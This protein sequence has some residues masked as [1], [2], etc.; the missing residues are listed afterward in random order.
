M[1]HNKNILYL[2]DML[3]AIEKIFIYVPFESVDE[4]VNANLQMN[5]NATCNLLI[6]VAEESKKIDPRLKKTHKIPWKNISNMRNI[7]AH[8]Y[9]GADPLYLML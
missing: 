9:R 1:L 7:L 3:S 8:D 5:Y 6:A 2:I 4:F